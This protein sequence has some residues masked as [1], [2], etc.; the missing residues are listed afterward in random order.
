MRFMAQVLGADLDELCARVAAN[1]ERVY[2]SWSDGAA[3]SGAEA[4]SS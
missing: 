1:T 4:G 3:A 2:G